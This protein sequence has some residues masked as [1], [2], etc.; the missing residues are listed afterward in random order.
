LGGILFGGFDLEETSATEALK[1][2]KI[3]LLLFHGEEDS[4]VPCEMSKECFEACFAPKKLY[5]FPKTDHGLC[6]MVDSERYLQGFKEFAQDF[7]LFEE[8]SA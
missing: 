6:F 3:P 7:K 1:A 2:C 5:T 4:I 8:K